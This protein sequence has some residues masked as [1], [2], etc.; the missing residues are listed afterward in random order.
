MGDLEKIIAGMSEAQIRTVLYLGEE[1]RPAWRGHCSAHYLAGHLTEKR[2]SENPM[3]RHAE[4]RLT[5]L[6]HQVRNL[7]I[8]RKGNEMSDKI[9]EAFCVS[10]GSTKRTPKGFCRNCGQYFFKSRFIRK[11][12]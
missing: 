12:Q 3:P 2:F 10:C 8:E 11:N 1:W 7:L 4:Y 5:P 9:M 6:G